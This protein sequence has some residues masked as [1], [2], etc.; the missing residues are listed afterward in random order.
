MCESRCQ[1]AA[2]AMPEA[3]PNQQMFEQSEKLAVRQGFEP[4]LEV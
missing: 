2:P 4:W 3:R 1:R